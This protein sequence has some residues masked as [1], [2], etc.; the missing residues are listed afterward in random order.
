M[1]FKVLQMTENV[2]FGQY[3]E[4]KVN[5]STKFQVQHYAATVKHKT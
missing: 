4:V 5:S 3:C 2:L 1:I